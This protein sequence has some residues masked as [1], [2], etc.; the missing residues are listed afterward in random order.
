VSASAT[1]AFL[2]TLR[3][4]DRELAIPML[5]RIN[6]LRE[7]ESD[8]E[9]LTNTFVAEGHDLH[10]ARRMALE[11]LVPDG[12][13]L[14][15]LR[16]I[17]SS[18]YARLSQRFGSSRLRLVERGALVIAASGVMLIESVALMGTD[19]RYGPSAFMWPLLSLS[20]LLFAAIVG[21]A[22]SLWIKKE[23]APLR[24]GALTVIALSAMVLITGVIG[25]PAD[26]YVLTDTL[27]ARP[28]EMGTLILQWLIRDGTLLSVS[29]LAAIAGGL[30]WFV[31]TQW[32][33]VL[34][35]ARAE[36]LG[37]AHRHPKNRHLSRGEVA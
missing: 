9:E 34:G 18:S 22:F 2:P 13:A 28:D 32:L 37:L 20:G 6:V 8:L 12:T 15:E 3:Q 30:A 29:I 19:L 27:V 4:L 23:H 5:D 17:H 10:S 21:T 24:S 31:F 25:A 7:L 16:R 26:L 11:A 36:T 35:A 1:R 33:A 14:G